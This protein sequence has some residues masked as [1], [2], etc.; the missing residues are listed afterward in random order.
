[1]IL[2]VATGQ[3]QDTAV[4]SLAGVAEAL[5]AAVGVALPATTE[6]VPAELEDALVDTRSRWPT[7]SAGEES[8][9]IDIS[10]ETLTLLAREIL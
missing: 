5:P 8:L 3:P 7:S 9:F 6:S 10:W 2:L 4:A 1:M